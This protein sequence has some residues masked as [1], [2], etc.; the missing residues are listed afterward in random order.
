MTRLEK[1][2]ELNPAFKARHILEA[3]R[4]FNGRE[5]NLAR[6][7]KPAAKIPGGTGWDTGLLAVQATKPVVGRKNPGKPEER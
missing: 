1:V 2:E 3:A 7:D 6:V 4:R 5:P